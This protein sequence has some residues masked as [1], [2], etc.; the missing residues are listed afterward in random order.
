M[1]SGYSDFVALEIHGDVS[2]GHGLAHVCTAGLP[3]KDR[4]NAQDQLPRAKWL[5]EK[6][7]GS[8][9]E[10]PDAIR[11]A[12]SG[13]EQNDGNDRRRPILL[14]GL[15][16]FQTRH[17]GHQQIE[18]D[19]RW[20]LLAGG[21]QRG[22]SILRSHYLKASPG[23]V[24]SDKVQNIDLIIS[25]QDAVGHRR[26]EMMVALRSGR[27]AGSRVATK[28]VLRDEKM[29]VTSHRGEISPPKQGGKQNS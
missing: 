26:Y 24:A 20:R 11:F 22:R 17:P 29:S 4:L 9:F 25:N 16:D 21:T 27:I 5:R 2:R 28:T 18:D 12:L 15:A 6:V 1:L 8:E 23:E 7:V 3:P 10:R 13:G 14:Q 19:Q